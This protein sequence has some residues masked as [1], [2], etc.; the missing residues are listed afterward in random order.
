M[1]LKNNTI[2]QFTDLYFGEYVMD[3]ELFD[4][5]DML[6]YDLRRRLGSEFVHT[7][8]DYIWNFNLKMINTKY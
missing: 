8:G 1:I 2:F 7:I 6:T 3:T 4:V 5:E